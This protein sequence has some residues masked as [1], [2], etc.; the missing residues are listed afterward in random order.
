MRILPPKKLY[1]PAVSIVAVV[2]L[3][4]ILMGVLTL[5]NLD[6]EKKVALRFLHEQG[7]ALMQSLEAGARTGMSTPLWG[8]DATETLIRETARNTSIAYI[9]L[10]DASG[11]VVHSSEPGSEGKWLGRQFQAPPNGEVSAQIVQPENGPAVYELVK[12]FQPLFEFQHM[13]HHRMMLQA[14]QHRGD[15]LILGLKMTSVEAITGAIV[16][17]ILVSRLRPKTVVA[18]DASRTTIA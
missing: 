8:A 14:D 12:E 9:L 4:L 3:L 6:R 7:L 15:I 13:P 1:L 10:A 2:M 16:A 18:S 17:R 11:E 5:R